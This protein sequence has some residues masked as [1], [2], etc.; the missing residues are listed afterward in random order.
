MSSRA[1]EVKVLDV[2]RETADAMSL[3]FDIPEDLTERFRYAPGQFVTLRVPSE[4]TG[5]VARCY[6]LCTSPYRDEHPAVTVKRTAGGYASNWICDNIA[7]GAVVMLLEPAGT[8]V[9]RSLADDVLLCAA[10]SGITPIV[11]IAKSV[12][13]AGSGHVALLYANRDRE[14]TIFADQLDL[15]AA[16]YR[17]RFAIEH[18]FEDQRGLPTREPL[19]H[20]VAA[21]RGRDSYLCGPTGFTEVA[22]QALADLYVPRDRIRLE[23]YRSLADN[24]FEDRA[25]PPQSAVPRSGQPTLEVEIDGDTRILDWPRDTVLLD[26]LLDNGIDAPYVCRES[27]CGTC[28]CTVREGRTRMLMNESLIDDELAQGLTLACQTLPQSDRVHIA[29]DQ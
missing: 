18:W 28:V 9:P 5:S 3:V 13:T 15:L 22:R 16:K 26:V 29:F 10:G 2:I 1:H 25:T 27:A 6:S 24:P 14:S 11:S 19:A 20:L 7:P 17:D 21:Y 4:R 8:F 12:L 23:E